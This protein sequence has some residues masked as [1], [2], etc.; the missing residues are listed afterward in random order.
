MHKGEHSGGAVQISHCK[1]DLLM[2]CEVPH[3]MANRTGA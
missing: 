1:A 2:R 3:K